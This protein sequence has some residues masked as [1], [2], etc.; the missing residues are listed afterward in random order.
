MPCDSNAEYD[1]LHLKL[2]EL[3]RAPVPD[4]VKI[5]ETIREL[6]QI[7]RRIKAEQQGYKGNNP[8]E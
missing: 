2:Q 1:R 5:D 8:N 3:H 4:L 6:E 7:R